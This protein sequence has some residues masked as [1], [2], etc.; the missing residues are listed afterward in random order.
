MLLQVTM[1][2]GL[3][4]FCQNW[5]I[6]LTFYPIWI[7]GPSGPIGIPPPTANA[8]E[9]NL[10]IKARRFRTW[11]ITVPLRKPITSGIPEPPAA[12]HMNWKINV[13]DHGYECHEKKLNTFLEFKV[14]GCKHTIMKKY[15]ILYLCRGPSRDWCNLKIELANEW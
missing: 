1:I 12:R 7:I 3:I 8:H 6:L 10:I 13:T 9:K 15:R 2:L 5:Q 4:Y 14:L 11:R